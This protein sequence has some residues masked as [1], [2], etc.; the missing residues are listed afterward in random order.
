SDP[1]GL[2]PARREATIRTW[3]PSDP[4]GLGPAR[5]EATIRT[6]EPSDPSEPQGGWGWGPAPEASRRINPARRETTRPPP[7]GEPGRAERDDESERLGVD[8]RPNTK[9]APVSGVSATA[10]PVATV[11]EPTK[12]SENGRA[13]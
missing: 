11:S 1:S 12:S 5:R 3:E 2:G 9:N 6:W 7:D 4:S 8:H 10:P 13:S